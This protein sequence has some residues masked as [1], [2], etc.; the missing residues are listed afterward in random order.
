LGL[1][2]FD[3]KEKE[4]DGCDLNVSE[5]LAQV[6]VRLHIVLNYIEKRVV[7]GL[8]HTLTRSV[9]LVLIPLSRLPN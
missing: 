2:K 7:D 6:K 5:E 3:A 1:P 4:P 8:S 9:D